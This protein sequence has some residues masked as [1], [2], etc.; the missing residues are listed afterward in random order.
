MLALI[1]CVCT[2]LG[3]CTDGALR[4]RGGQ[5]NSGR[6]EVCNSA[7]WGTV[8]DDNW[9]IN[10]ASVAC[11]QLGFPQGNRKILKNSIILY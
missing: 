10:D 6:V 8:C 2:L 4:L 7:E 1:C 11:R 3:V 5:Y 9:D